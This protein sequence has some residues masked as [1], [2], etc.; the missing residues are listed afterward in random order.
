MS[1]DI[2]FLCA[3][4]L[5]RQ[6]QPVFVLSPF[7]SG[8]L[9]HTVHFWRLQNYRKNC[10]NLLDDG[11]FLF[12]F[13]NCDVIYRMKHKK[14]YLVKLRSQRFIFVLTFIFFVS[15]ISNSSLTICRYKMSTECVF[16]YIP[17]SWTWKIDI[18]QQSCHFRFVVLL[19]LSFFGFL[20]V[21]HSTIIPSFNLSLL[22]I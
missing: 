21:S 10:I 4:N 1:G 19:H 14:E 7:C 17:I 18:I 9:E 2:F 5:L 13:L 11:L 3:L 22:E 20:F 8:F 12:F 6:V 16:F 15:D